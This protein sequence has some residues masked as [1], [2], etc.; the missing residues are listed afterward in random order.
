MSPGVDSASKNV[1]QENS[2]VY[3]WPVRNDDDFTTF[4]VPKVEKIRSLN[5]PDPQ[6]HVQACSGKT[7]PLLL[8]L[9]FKE[10]DTQKLVYKYLDGHVV[11]IM[12]TLLWS[13]PTLLKL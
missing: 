9:S 2:R 11:V 13:R 8:L 12:V 10:T 4:I 5:H 1:Y 6:G 3:R 7:L